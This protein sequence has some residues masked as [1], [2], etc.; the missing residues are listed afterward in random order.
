MDMQTASNAATDVTTCVAGGATALTVVTADAAST[1]GA[2]AFPV[3]AAQWH[4]SRPG[5]WTCE[6]CT[7]PGP[8]TCP[9]CC[10][11]LHCAGR[12]A[13]GQQLKRTSACSRNTTRRNWSPDG[14]SDAFATSTQ[15]TLDEAGRQYLQIVQP[16]T[17]L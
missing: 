14:D 9:R 10:R 2:G 15:M 13:R 6:A 17:Q 4:G 11:L 7:E 12:S 8:K 1:A 3:L 5:P 16:A